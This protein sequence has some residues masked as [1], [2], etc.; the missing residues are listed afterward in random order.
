[1]ETRQRLDT[2]AH[3][4]KRKEQHIRDIQAK[5]DQ[6]HQPSNS[7]E[8]IAALAIHRHTYNIKLAIFIVG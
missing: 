3:D 2:L 5:L 8:Y 6:P 7:C 4:M 1:M